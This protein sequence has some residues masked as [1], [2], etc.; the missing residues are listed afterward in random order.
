MS[1]FFFRWACFSF[2]ELVFFRWACFSFGELVLWPGSIPGALQVI[3]LTCFDSFPV[4]TK[5]KKWP[6]ELLSISQVIFAASFPLARAFG[7]RLYNRICLRH[8]CYIPRSVNLTAST[9]PWLIMAL[10]MSRF[11]CMIANGRPNKAHSMIVSNSGYPWTTVCGTH[12][13]KYMVNFW[14][15]FI[16]PSE[17]QIQ[18]AIKIALKAISS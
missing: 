9:I 4:T 1:L 7:L 16:S 6:V 17:Y 14:K 11:F 13:I 8:G 5:V 3:F 18:N 10:Q 15:R 2:D 12:I